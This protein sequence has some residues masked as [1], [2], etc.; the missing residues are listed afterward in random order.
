V[1]LIKHITDTARWA[2]FYRA[3]ESDRSDAVFIDPLAR[4]LA[5]DR[6]AE[7][8]AAFQMGA[9]N[10]W[11]F[12]ARTWLYDRYIQE[13]VAHGVDLVLSLAAGL[14]ARPYRMELP[15]TLSWVEVDLPDMIDFKT[16]ALRDE[17]PRCRLQRVALD[18][19][20]GEAR[21]DFLQSQRGSRGLVMTEGLLAYLPSQEVASLARDL[22]ATPVLQGWAT[23]IMSP[24]LLATMTPQMVRL[25][26]AGV[27]PLQF[28]PANGPAWF[29]P[30]GWQVR[31]VGSLLKTAHQLGRLPP[32]MR[33]MAALPETPERPGVATWAGVCWFEKAAA[34]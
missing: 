27:S 33:P 4:R 12:V 28:A 25:F 13:A 3:Q 7:I 11:S 31:Q 20:Q 17:T 34:T 1:A 22:A 26:G 18:L 32:Q 29:R 21:R 5:G 10:S 2:A 15:A 23:D 30:L 19:T 9:Q 14:D 8:A 16:D 24:A 6:G